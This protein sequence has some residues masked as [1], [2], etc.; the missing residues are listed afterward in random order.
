MKNFNKS[1]LMKRAWGIYKGGHE[2]TFS[3]SLRR[4]WSIEKADM[5]RIVKEEKYRQDTL[6]FLAYIK[7]NPAMLDPNPA[8]NP[9]AM[10]KYLND[11][12]SGSKYRGGFYFGD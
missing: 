5:A 2:R 4:A 8:A 7:A 6:K 10:E 12:R 9:V 11:V 1:K 3:S